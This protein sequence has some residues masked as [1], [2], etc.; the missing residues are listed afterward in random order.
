M[1]LKIRAVPEAKEDKI[2]KI[3]TDTWR[4]WV[5]VPAERNLANQGIIKLVAHE[6]G[7]KDDQIRI[8]SGH[9]SPSKIFSLPDNL[10]L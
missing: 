2:E 8:V 7:L 10:V 3:S 5:Q 9:H 6:L 1:Y 4:V